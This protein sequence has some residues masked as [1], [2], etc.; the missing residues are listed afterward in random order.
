MLGI[1]MVRRGL[2]EPEMGIL[3]RILEVFGIKVG[4]ILKIGIEK[5]C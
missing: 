2:E 4:G 1:G 5:V 3:R